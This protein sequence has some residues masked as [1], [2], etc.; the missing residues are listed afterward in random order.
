MSYFRDEAP[1]PV[2]RKECI[3]CRPA[4]A[5]C[6]DYHCDR[7]NLNAFS[8]LSLISVRNS[9]SVKDARSEKEKMEMK[10]VSIG[11]G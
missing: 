5:I 4:D 6:A 11:I 7:S 9:D 10:M 8:N 2:G 1:R 3:E